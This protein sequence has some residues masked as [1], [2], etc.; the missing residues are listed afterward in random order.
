MGHEG[1]TI[2]VNTPALPGCDA[3]YEAALISSPGEADALLEAVKARAPGRRKT[4][5]PAFL[6]A[7]S[8]NGWSPRICGV[9]CGGQAVGLVYAKEKTIVG[10]RTGLVYADA[11]L[12]NLV[13]AIPGHEA[14]VLSAALKILI[15]LPGVHGLR[16]SIPPAGYER[17][18]IAELQSAAQIDVAH[19]P[20]R[21]HS[22][23]RFPA[24]Y[25]EF[26]AGLGNRT[27]RNF[28]YYRKKFENSAN[29]YEETVSF[30]EFKRAAEELL[31]RRVVGASPSGLARAIAVL[32]AVD[33]PILTGLRTKSG[34]WISILGGWYAGADPVVFMQMNN[35]RDYPDSSLAVVL[36]SWLIEKAI[37]EGASG[38]IFW[39]G[40][41]GPLR[42]YAVPLATLAA[43]LDKSNRAWRL[44]RQAAAKL[45]PY[46]PPSRFPLLDWVIPRPG[47]HPGQ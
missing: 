5:T 44:V 42:K 45:S 46:L 9:T 8:T 7:S 3:G 31:R 14:N 6:I 16:I 29:V 18:V 32:S 19:R 40:V 43:Y 17:R 20:V 37:A 38:L 26:L 28:R 11:V 33:A 13:A 34:A 10:I 39:A 25:D 23:L 27:R 1:C 41:G 4:Y 15:N 12:D 30:P 36:R 47:T 24:T 2:G 35:E 22:M 21:N